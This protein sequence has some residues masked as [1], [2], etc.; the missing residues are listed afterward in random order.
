MNKVVSSFG[1]G[2]NGQPYQNNLYSRITGASLIRGPN[3]L[4]SHNNGNSSVHKDY[5]NYPQA[6]NYAYSNAYKDRG[7]NS[8]GQLN[9]Y[10]Y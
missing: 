7:N 10:E 6:N 3:A 8:R 5:R 1:K 9:T 2:R 4:D